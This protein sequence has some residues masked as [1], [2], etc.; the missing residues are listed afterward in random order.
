VAPRRGGAR[1]RAWRTAALAAACIGL[2]AAVGSGLSQAA[3][4]AADPAAPRTPAGI[5][6]GA[7]PDNPHYGEAL[8]TSASAEGV[9]ATLRATAG[10]EEGLPVA[11][12]ATLA[13]SGGGA[14]PF[15][16][17][18]AAP[19]AV[20]D[21]QLQ[22]LT[23]YESSNP[24]EPLCV[25][26]FHGGPVPTVL[27]GFYSGGAH[28]CTI[29]RAYSESGGTW[30][31]V[32]QPIGDPA[33]QVTRVNDTPAIVTADDSFAY[34]FTDYAA[35]GLPVEVL[36]VDHGKFTDVTRQFPSVIRADATSW[37]T[38]F[39]KSPQDNLGVL[40]AW[41]A[42]RCELGHQAQVMATLDSLQAR[43]KLGPNV[44]VTQSQPFWPSG[45]G[46]VTALRT[47]LA[48][49]GYCPAG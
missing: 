28:C 20:G 21:I 12:D 49:H 27:L 17:P 1:R 30:T 46:Y 42:D 4:A 7:T 44:S 32:D 29:V 10:T 22:S 19:Q 36:T 31:S 5:A 43:H 45:S 34:E 35:S 25:V 23:N 26:G 8:S 13:I 18:V 14:P 40:A 9:R 11:N 39:K 41:A 2:S 38:A 48:K 37:W 24:T 16:E 3:G 15:D 33:V 47:F 6:C